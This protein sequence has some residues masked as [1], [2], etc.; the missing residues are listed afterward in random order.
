MFHPWNVRRKWYTPVEENVSL[1]FKSDSI[2]IYFVKEPIRQRKERHEEHRRERESCKSY[3]KLHSE[4]ECAKFSLASLTSNKTPTKVKRWE[5]GR[6]FHTEFV[7]KI[8]FGS[9][10]FGSD[11]ISATFI[12]C[13]LRRTYA[14]LA[15]FEANNQIKLD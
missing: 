12:S 15:N 3:S 9:M 13:K 10:G 11:Q 7:P 4:M 1:F 5:C 14:Q 6:E 2:S 8:L